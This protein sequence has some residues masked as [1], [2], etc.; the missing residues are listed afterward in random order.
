MKH[1]E[2]FV[3]QDTKFIG[4]ENSGTALELIETT[5]QIVNST[6]VSNRKGLY[7]RCVLLN[8]KHGCYRDGF[9][10]GAIIATNSAIDISQSKFGYNGADYGGAIFAEQHSIINVSGNVF[11]NNN[12]TRYG[13]V[14]YSSSST[15]TI[16]A[17]EFHDNNATWGGVLYSDFSSNITIKGSEVHGNNAIF[18]GVLY[19][20]I[21]TIM[22]E[23][24]EF[25][26][27]NA[28]RYGG[29]LYSYSCSTVTIEVSE[30]HN[31]RATKGGGVLYS[32]S[33]N[34]TIE[35]SGFHNNNVTWWGGVLYSISSIIMIEVSKF[36]DNNA[37][38]SGGA[39]YSISSTI[40]IEDSEFHNNSAASGGGIL[41]SSSSNITIKGSRFHSN[42]ATWGGVLHFSSSNIKIKGSRFHNNNAAEYGGVLHCSSSTITMFGSNFTKNCSPIGAVIFAIDGSKIQHH[43]SLVIANNSADRYAI[44]YLSDS[45]FSGHGSEKASFSSNCGSLEAFNSNVTFTSYAMFLNNKPPHTAKDN[46]QEGGA[47]TLFQS[48]AFFAGTCIFEYNLAEN[49]GA[50]LSIESKLYLN[51]NVTIA[52]NTAVRNGGGVYLSNSEL[53][54]RQGSTFKLVG[55]TAAHKGGG[56]HAI[57]SSIK[58]IY[59]LKFSEQQ[60]TGTRINFIKNTSEKGGGLSL[61]A[62]TKLYILKYNWILLTLD[63]V[64]DTNTIIFTTNRADYGGAVYVDDDTNS[65]TTCSSEPKSECFF[66]VLAF[67]GL[68]SDHLKTQSIIYFSQ[69]YANI[70]GSTLYGGLLDR[71]AVSQFAEVQHKHKPGQNYEYKGNGLSYFKDISIGEN[72]LISSHPV[73]VC[74]CTVNEHICSNHSHIEIKKGQTFKLS[75][76]AVDQIGIPVSATIQ[77]S[78]NFAGSGLD[79]GQLARKIPAECTDLTFNIVSLHNSENLTLYALDGPCKD[80]EL[81]R[82][83]IE[84]HF[85]PC[86]CPIGLQVS[87]INKTNCTCKCHSDISQYV[88]MCDGHTGTFVKQPKSRAWIS[89][90]NDTNVNGYLVFPNCPFDYCL[91][92]SSPAD[93]NQ[94]NG[95]D[96]Q[97]ALNRSSLL[98]GSCQPGLSLSLGSSRCLPCPSHWPALLIAITIAAIL[99]G[100]ALVALLL[101]LNMTVAV[102]TL[103]GL[104]F[105]ANVVYANKSVLLPFQTT[106][107]I[108][109]FISWLN[110]ELGIDTCY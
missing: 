33:S 24:S 34:I 17:S 51:G 9:I 77:T 54:C 86:R 57:S 88:E 63:Y 6:F 70:S 50:I 110:L 78:L 109:V 71:C 30:F 26:S 103:N 97:C 59:A 18:G 39:L 42:I 20:S 108:T 101:V 28:S 92:N 61:E 102:G 67:H 27:N 10:G 80:A 89:Y 41:H 55:N 38:W 47:L 14:L 13:G 2:E 15:I 16:E 106:N 37:T 65:G 96:A 104:I 11:I 53:S 36:H 66:Q 46:F 75:V 29:V 49:G 81:S 94:Q 56:L 1:V 19:S 74:L 8:S 69:N 43:N 60:Y 82:R 85:L 52:H 45:E 48:N 95:A 93:L 22:I 44:I 98:C 12:A 21:S 99:A 100:I 72:S 76:V 32:S 62:N 58:A 83:S 79:E 87:G 31:N 5:A 25:H 73:Q 35:E 90:I 7:R 84:I 105:Y 107:F 40:T 64:T 91:L 4:Q 3:I 68:E 23:A